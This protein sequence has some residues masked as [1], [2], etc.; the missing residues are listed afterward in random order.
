MTA[1][2]SWSNMTIPGDLAKVELVVGAGREEIRIF[3]PPIICKS[4]GIG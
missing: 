1:F 4:C 2:K 3:T